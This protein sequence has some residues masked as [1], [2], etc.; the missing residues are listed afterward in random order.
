MQITELSVKIKL[1]FLKHKKKS[2]LFIYFKLWKLVLSF[3]IIHCIE[4]FQT[5]KSAIQTR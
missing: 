5:G 4:T 1:W 3:N 2:H